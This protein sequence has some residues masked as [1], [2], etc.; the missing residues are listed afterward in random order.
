MWIRNTKEKVGLNSLQHKLTEE[1]HTRRSHSSILMDAQWKYIVNT[2]LS[3]AASCCFN[4]FSDK[5]LSS[6]RNESQSCF[7]LLRDSTFISSFWFASKLKVRKIRLRYLYQ[8]IQIPW[9]LAICNWWWI[10][11]RICWLNIISTCVAMSFISNDSFLFSQ[12][13]LSLL[14]LFKINKVYIGKD[15]HGHAGTDKRTQTELIIPFT[16]AT[17]C[18]TQDTLEIACMQVFIQVEK[19]NSQN[20]WTWRCQHREPGF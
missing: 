11:T 2:W 19:I 3:K 1:K 10:D 13:S 17:F 5:T 8:N 9:W 20:T 12:P 4:N 18:E 6:S 15:G 14:E 16:L 7:I